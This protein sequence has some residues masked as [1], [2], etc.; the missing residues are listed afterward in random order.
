MGGGNGVPFMF[1]PCHEPSSSALK[2][3]LGRPIARRALGFMP[4]G[5]P[6]RRPALVRES[7]EI[8]VDEAKLRDYVL[9]DRHPRGRHK[10][11]VFRSRLGLIQSDAGWLCDALLEA[12]LRLR[13]EFRPLHADAFG[14]R[15][16][17]DILM[18]TTNGAAIVRTA[19][20]VRTDEDM[21]RF[22]TCYVL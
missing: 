6:T 18:T 11:R 22:V 14:R 2:P 12:A 17:L 13:S 9:N 1:D 10:A 4:A 5:S 3:I 15:Y 21:V 7:A 19:W 16:G 8:V 20:I